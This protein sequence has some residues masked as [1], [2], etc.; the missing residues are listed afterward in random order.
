MKDRADTPRYRGTVEVRQ[1]DAMAG[2]TFYLATSVRGSL[3][4]RQPRDRKQVVHR[5]LRLLDGVRG[6]A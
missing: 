1:G 4:P 6:E 2:P 3:A 5:L